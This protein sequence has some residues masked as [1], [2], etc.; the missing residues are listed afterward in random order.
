[1]FKLDIKQEEPV[2]EQG[3]RF[4]DVYFQEAKWLDAVK[5]RLKKGKN[6]III[7]HGETGEGKSYLAMKMCEKADKHFSVKNI[8]FWDNLNEFI[9]LLGTLPEESWILIDDAGALLDA[10]EFMTIINK[11]ISYVLEMFRMK[12]ICVIF[13]APNR[14]MIDKNARRVAHYLIFQ[15]DRGYAAVYRQKMNFRG[16]IYPR[17][18]FHFDG[19]QLPSKALIEAYEKKKVISFNK[20]LEEE[21]KRVR[22]L[23]TEEEE[24]EERTYNVPIR[25]N[26]SDEDAFEEFTEYVKPIS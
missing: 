9:H 8:I 13:T 24:R 7:I 21:S 17:F 10:R 23:E 1:M 18:L 3:S 2:E 15:K 16:D 19:V 12:K 14:M 5:S 4:H 11:M 6:I 22:P 25:S 26:E 20:M